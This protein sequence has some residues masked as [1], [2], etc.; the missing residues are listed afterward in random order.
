[1]MAITDGTPKQNQWA[2]DIRSKFVFP[3][4][5]NNLL[6]KAIDVIKSIDCADFWIEHKDY[7]SVTLLR[8]LQAGKLK[9][10][11]STMDV[12]MMEQDGTIKTGTM[13]YDGNINY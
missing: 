8:L 10:K 11:G 1:M 7:D 6:N 9:Y 2:E 12:M 5:E 13:D 4:S 3:E